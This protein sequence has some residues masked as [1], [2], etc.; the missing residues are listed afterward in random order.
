MR[1]VE[2]HLVARVSVNGGHDTA[3]NGISVVKSLSHGSKTVC[4]AGS[5]GNDLIFFGKFLVVNVEND[6]LKIVARGSGNNDFLRAGLNVSHRLFFGSVES[7]TFQNYV[8]AEFTPRK[9]RSLRASVD[10]DFLSVYGDGAGNNNGFA[11]FAENRI[12]ISYGMSLSNVTA[13]SRIVFQKVSKH[14]GARKVVDRN[15]FIAFR[16]EHLSERKTTDSSETVNRYFYICHYIC[17]PN[18]NIT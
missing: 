2:D 13:L 4:R 7:G 5:G 3:L 16:A 1:S 6:G 9:I 12:L 15:N 10:G 18:I 14:F 8:Y 11:V 17:P